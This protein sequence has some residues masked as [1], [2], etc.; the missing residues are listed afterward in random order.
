[1]HW[2]IQEAK[3]RFSEVLRAADDEGPQYITRHGEESA[4]ILSIREYR[5]LKGIPSF[6][7]LLREPPY[8]DIESD[9]SDLRAEVYAPRF[10]EADYC[11]ELSGRH[12][13][14]IRTP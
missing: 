1:M 8:V 6:K 4:V 14:D 5:E 11:G 3:A 13:R 7:E 12:Q 2:Q 10:P 9:L